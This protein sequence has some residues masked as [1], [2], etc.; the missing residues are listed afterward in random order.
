[1]DFMS[2]ETPVFT[3]TERIAKQVNACI[4]YI[5]IS[6]PK[7]G[8]YQAVFKPVK[9]REEA[10]KEYPIT[11]VYM[12]MLEETIVREPSYWLWSHNRWK[13]TRALLEQ[14]LIEQEKRKAERI[15]ANSTKEVN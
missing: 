5:D 14:R 1:M 3:G 13:R 4:Y 2:Q 10:E 6:R 11:E 8:Y 15:K 7:R 12:R 9:W